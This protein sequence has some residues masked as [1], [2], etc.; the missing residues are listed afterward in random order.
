[1]NSWKNIFALFKTLKKK[2]KLQLIF[3]LFSSLLSGLLEAFSMATFLPFLSILINPDGIKKLPFLDFLKFFFNTDNSNNM[4]LQ[5]TIVFI[6]ITF[7]TG[8]IRILNI[9]F[10]AKISALIGSDVG[11]KVYKNSLYLPYIQ[12]LRTNSSSL[13]NAIAY[14]SPN[15][16]SVFYSANFILTSSFVFIFIIIGLIT[17]DLKLT[18]LIAIIISIIYFFIGLQIRKSLIKNSKIIDN[19]GKMQ[20]QT[21]QEGISF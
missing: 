7:L 1:M 11:V 9:W 18:I 5:I 13:V 8:L 12:Q 15:V 2:R 16:L 14:Q 3:L 21:L 4:L 17:I 19:F 10:A 20:I 6:I